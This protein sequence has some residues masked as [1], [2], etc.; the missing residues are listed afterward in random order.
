MFRK[1]GDLVGTAGDPVV[2]AVVAP[3]QATAREA[4]PMGELISVEF[5]PIRESVEYLDASPLAPWDEDEDEVEDI[6][7]CGAGHYGTLGNTCIR[8]ID[9]R[10]EE[11]GQ[12]V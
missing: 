2:D 10:L 3:V 11:C 6:G 1:L 12:F 5:V 8:R 4:A 7:V 9:G